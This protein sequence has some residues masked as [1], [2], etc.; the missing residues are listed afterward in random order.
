MVND[1]NT[2]ILMCSGL[3][4]CVFC[5]GAIPF[6]Y[7]QMIYTFSLYIY[8][9]RVKFIK[10]NYFRQNKALLGRDKCTR[11]PRPQYELWWSKRGRRVEN[12]NLLC[13]KLLISYYHIDIS[14]QNVSN[15]G[16][17][18]QDKIQCTSYFGNT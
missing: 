12:R 10:I 4:T 16:Y 8:H 1:Q 9:S 6:C 13:S 15:L 11:K 18:W 5:F 2:E 7:P 14:M 17:F 3:C